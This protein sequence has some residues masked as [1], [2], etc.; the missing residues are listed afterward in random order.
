VLELRNFL[1]REHRPG[2]ILE[3][4]TYGETISATSE[5]VLEQTSTGGNQ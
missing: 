1:I 2:G 5:S 4:S 3:P